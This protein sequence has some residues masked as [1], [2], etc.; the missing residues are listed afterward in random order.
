[1]WSRAASSGV[2]GEGA[3]WRSIAWFAIGMIAVVRAMATLQTPPR[4]ISW[5]QHRT[6]H[7]SSK[8][9]LRVGLSDARK[10]RFAPKQPISV[11]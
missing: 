11:V 7:V 5:G 1:M 8:Y 2:R 6:Q 3:S 10:Q 4:H 9:A